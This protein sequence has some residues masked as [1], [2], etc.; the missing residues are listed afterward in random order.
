VT[1]AAAESPAIQELCDALGEKAIRRSKEDIVR[2]LKDNSWLSPVVAEELDRRSEQEGSVLGIAAVV[3]PRTEDDVLR[4]AQIAARYRL[5][6]TPRGGGTSNFGLIT[7][8]RGGLIFDMRGLKGEC[9]FENGAMRAPAGVMQ[10]AIESMAR[11]HGQELPMLTTTYATATIAGWVVGGHVG[12]GSGMYGA[13]WDGIVREL[14][15][16]T[17][18][19]EP[20]TLV[21]T[22]RQVD[23]VL[24]TFGTVGLVTEVVLNT[25]EAREWVEALAF[26]PTFELGSQFV[27]VLSHDEH[28]FHR[29]LTAQEE[30]LMPALRRPLGDAFQ[31]GAGVLMIVDETQLA[32]VRSVAESLSGRFIEWQKWELSGG[33]RPSIAAMVY[34]HRMLWVKRFLPDAAFLHVYFDPD[35]PDAGVRLLKDRFGDEVLVEM[36]FIRSPWLLSALGYG[37]EGTL[38]AAV[39]TIVDGAQPGKVGDVLKYCEEVGIR[40]Q[41]PHTSVLEDTGVFSDIT[42]IVQLKTRADPYNLLNPGK[43]RSAITRS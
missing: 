38:P 41:N 34:G 8:E 43:L 17:V 2:M 21:L 13:V 16:V 24:H 26:F 10:G 29:A 12:L 37:T 42:P 7:P 32:E 3:A 23:P 39:I 27:S 15:L 31:E 36:K 33:K 25:V 30:A 22:S 20:T 1:T 5:P 11:A 6:I 19:E 9:R 40:Y 35:D 4:A 14:R 18:E 28:Y